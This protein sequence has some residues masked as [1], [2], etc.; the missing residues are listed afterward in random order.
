MSFRTT[1]WSLRLW[2]VVMVLFVGARLSRPGSWH[3]PESWARLDPHPSPA[4]VAQLCSGLQGAA[5]RAWPHTSFPPYG[6]G[7]VSRALRSC[8]AFLQYAASPKASVFGWH[9]RWVWARCGD[10]IRGN[11]AA[12][13]AFTC[14]VFVSCT[15]WR[16]AYARSIR[17]S[18]VRECSG[19]VEVTW[20]GAHKTAPAAAAGVLGPLRRTV[21]SVPLTNG[22][23]VEVFRSFCEARPRGGDGAL[24][25][26][27]NG[28]TM[29]AQFVNGTLRRL[30]VLAGCF[31]ASASGTCAIHSLR[32][33]SLTE[34]RLA[35]ADTRTIQ[36]LAWWRGACRVAD[37]YQSV[38][39]ECLASAVRSV[40]ELL[41][42]QHSPGVVSRAGVV[43]VEWLQSGVL[44]V[45]EGLDPLCTV[46]ECSSSDCD[47]DVADAESA[48]EGKQGEFSLHCFLCA[49]YVAA[50]DCSGALCSMDECPQTVCRECWPDASVDVWCPNHS[51]PGSP[52]VLAA[53]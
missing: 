15:A 23:F 5:V 33:A 51:V 14:L 2:S 17:W 37:G 53:A 35:G 41:L 39:R 32:V 26:S 9:L 19:G 24:V 48:R 42:V 27:T 18:D 3:R 47:L 12:L 11:L 28:R 43:S 22:F 36:W 44:P 30:L 6:G 1:A 16:G 10:A 52:G 4:Y 29:T 25:F 13:C 21:F 20:S 34:M 49:A 45:S 7:V 50:D 31:P 38:A 40:G 8:G 46:S